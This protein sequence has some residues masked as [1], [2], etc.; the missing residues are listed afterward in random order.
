LV[1]KADIKLKTLAYRLPRN[2]V[3]HEK[4]DLP[5]LVLDY[6]LKSITLH[7][8]WRDALKL[9]HSRS[10][11]PLEN[12]I[13]YVKNLAPDQIEFFF[14]DLSRKGFL[15]QEGV[16][17][18][19]DYPFVSIIIPVRNR[20]AQI[21][22]C[23]HSLMRLKYPTEKLEI[24]VV[25][26]AST[27]HTPQKVAAFPVNLITLKE[28][29]QA[30]Y[31]RN[32]AAHKA[33]G[34]IL[35][36]IDSDCLADQFWLYE[37]VPAFKDPSLSAIGG[38]VDSYYV[39]TPLDRYEQVRSS[40]IIG[41]RMRRSSENENFFYVP[42]CNLLVRRNIFKKLNGFD[43]DLFVGEDV[44]FCWRLQD[45]GYFI[46]FRP[47]GK[48]YHK[49]RNE[50]KPFSSRRFDYGTSEP[51]L[52]QRH[53]DRSKQMFF[54]LGASIFW[55]MAV[56]AIT[57]NSIFFIMFGAVTI[58]TDALIKFVGMMQRGV[59]I[60]FYKLFFAVFRTYFAF[61]YHF[62]AFISRYYLIFS[63]IIV[64]LSPL[65]FMIVLGMHLF[66]GVTEYFIKKPRLNL[67]SFLF[68]FSLEQLSYQLGVWWYCIK[69]SSFSAINPT[70]TWRYPSR[71]VG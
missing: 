68:Y 31:C 44:D 9:L 19:T 26:D 69:N 33:Q 16:S 51:M 28:N 1:I 24:I 39:D 43:E 18:L 36:F 46:E 47:L 11:V 32:F 27:D 63:A 7:P 12:I 17:R 35:A 59:Y 4:N 48:I 5:C 2:I 50:L 30:S 45:A 8:F 49:H 54:P 20:P 22:E 64:F 10:F 71:K 57:C 3:Y 70:I 62:C 55:M 52:Q 42:S 13:P 34:D 23:L 6:P 66:V 25:D 29:K 67:F 14:N 58:F 40:L 65:V 41:Q 15:E 53:P 61:F 37:L 21:E 56:L 38:I 60:P